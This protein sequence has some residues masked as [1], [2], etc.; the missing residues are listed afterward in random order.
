MLVVISF[1]MSSIDYLVGR[2]KGVKM[3]A[4]EREKRNF[5][6]VCAQV[7]MFAGVCV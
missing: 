4:R 2:G 5:V 7:N 1:E 3:E 6:L